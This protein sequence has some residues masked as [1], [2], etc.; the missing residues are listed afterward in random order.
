VFS[1]TVGQ[2]SVDPQSGRLARK[3][4]PTVAAGVQPR[5]IAVAAGRVYVA[6]SGGD[7]IS[8]YAADGGGSLSQLAPAVAAPPSPFGLALSPDGN[9]LYVAGFTNGEVGQYDVAGNGTLTAKDPATVEAN[10]SPLAVVAVRPRD[11]QAPTVDLRTPP[12]GAQY[13]LGADV[14]A[15]YSCADEG[16]SGLASCTGDVP[17]GDALDTSA[18][19]PHAF[20]V[21]ARDRAGQET[22]V[23]HGYTVVEPLLSFEGFLGPIQDGSVVHAGDAIPIVFSLGGFRGLDVLADG[24]PT[25]VQVDCDDPGEPT[26]GEPAESQFDRGLR[27]NRSTGHYVFTWQTKR[28]WAGTCRSFIL[29]LRDGTV[30]RLTVSFRSAWRWHRHW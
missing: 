6:N 27:F 10:S 26:G 30:A 25:S 14:A 24:S 11:E 18:P 29:G 15:D 7:S 22:A 5:G 20:T 28:A 3:A 12:E 17:D 23:N 8:Q 21:T 16:G 2:F 19:G 13:E 4:Q 9:S 1:G